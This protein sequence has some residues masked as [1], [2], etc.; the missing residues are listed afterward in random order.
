M[1]GLMFDCGH[2]DSVLDDEYGDGS[3]WCQQ[4]GGYAV[5]DRCRECGSLECEHTAIGAP[6]SGVQD[7]T[8]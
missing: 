7:G 8:E 2:F 6:C 1:R 5:Y 3:A 4:C